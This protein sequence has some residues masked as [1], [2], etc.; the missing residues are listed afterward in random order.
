LVPL[1]SKADQVENTSDFLVKGRELVQQEPETIQWFAFKYASTPNSFAIIDT[2]AT[3]SGQSAHLAGPLAS[4]LRA[5]AG[6][7]LSIASDIAQF[8]VLASTVKPGAEAPGALKFGLKVRLIPKA[9]Q[10]QAL[11]DFLLVSSL[12]HS[13]EPAGH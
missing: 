7:L 3:Q 6:E 12:N 9:G 1:I 4:A 8:K 5:N 11:K 2:F 10:E 13:S